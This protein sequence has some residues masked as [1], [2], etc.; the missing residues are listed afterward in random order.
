MERL[1]G[2]QSTTEESVSADSETQRQHKVIREQEELMVRR[3]AWG[4]GISLYQL[5]DG[6]LSLKFLVDEEA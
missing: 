1:S 4:K 2:N 3:R 6:K 5:R